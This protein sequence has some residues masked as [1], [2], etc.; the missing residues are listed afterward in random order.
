MANSRMVVK[1]L[2]ISE[3]TTAIGSGTRVV[4]NA[5]SVIS[6]TPKLLGKNVVSIPATPAIAHMSMIN[7][8]FPKLIIVKV[9][10]IK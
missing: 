5:A 1:N 7:I 6:V 2:L 4:K 9:F 3:M 8:R 10:T